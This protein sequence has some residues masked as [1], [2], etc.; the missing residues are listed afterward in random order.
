MSFYAVT[1]EFLVKIYKYS[2]SKSSKKILLM[3]LEFGYFVD[4]DLTGRKML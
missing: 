2:I 4:A 3:I 1:I